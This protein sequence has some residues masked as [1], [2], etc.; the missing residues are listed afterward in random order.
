[1]TG[2]AHSYQFARRGLLTP[3]TSHRLARQLALAVG[4]IILLVAGYVL[5]TQFGSST[6]PP[7]HL[8]VPMSTTPGAGV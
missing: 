8:E 4:A 3:W 6:S 5:A 1:M 7:L 2:V